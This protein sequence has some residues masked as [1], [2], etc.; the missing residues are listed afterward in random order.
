MAKSDPDWPHVCHQKN[1]K[2][3]FLVG[4]FPSRDEVFPPGRKTVSL[5]L[6][7]PGFFTN[8]FLKLR[9]H[10]RVAAQAHIASH[11][12][13][14]IAIYSRQ[15]TH[16]ASHL[17][18]PIFAHFVLLNLSEKSILNLSAAIYNHLVL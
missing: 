17:T 7:R 8:D 3:Y 14:S 16:L 6:A 10:L 5:D 13:A 12:E 2:Q 11:S 18:V 15:L 4:Y 9:T 1:T